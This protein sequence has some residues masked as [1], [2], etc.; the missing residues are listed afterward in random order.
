MKRRR[1]AHISV[2]CWGGAVWPQA[3]ALLA[4]LLAFWLPGASPAQ[5]ATHPVAVV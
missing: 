1:A 4:G 5:A 3:G 2:R